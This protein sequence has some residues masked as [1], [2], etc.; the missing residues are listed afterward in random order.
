MDNLRCTFMVANR[1]RDFGGSGT[2]RGGRTYTTPSWW[3]LRLWNRWTAFA[4]HFWQYRKTWPNK[5]GIHATLGPLIGR[6]G[7][8]M[9]AKVSVLGKVKLE[10]GSPAALPCSAW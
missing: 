6:P 10:R 2:G 8:I 4:C 5:S 9:D 1:R 7:V 3:C